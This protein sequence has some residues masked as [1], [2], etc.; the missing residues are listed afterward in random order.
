MEKNLEGKLHLE[1]VTLLFQTD[2]FEY[3]SAGYPARSNYTPK[4]KPSEIYSSKEIDSSFFSILEMNLN[5]IFDCEGKE[6]KIKIFPLA[7]EKFSFEEIVKYFKEKNNKVELIEG[8]KKIN[9]KIRSINYSFWGYH[10]ETSERNNHF[11]DI[12]YETW[13]K[14]GSKNDIPF[15]FEIVSED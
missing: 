7:K 3:E 13:I 15:K 5:G 14:F 9:V 1:K 4:L 11:L 2:G 8:N 10:Q 6:E 12:N